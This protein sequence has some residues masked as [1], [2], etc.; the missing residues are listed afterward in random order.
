MGGG[1]VSEIAVLITSIVG[2]LSATGAAIAWLWN[3]IEK[4]FE[5]VETA[6]EECR[7]RE[8]RSAEREGKHLTVIELLWQEVERKT[9]GPNA[10]LDRAKR[11]LDD[12]KGDD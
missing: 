4:R 10:V 6:L 7:K 11:I 12:L 1:V 3:K 5:K 8:A 9:R 2:A